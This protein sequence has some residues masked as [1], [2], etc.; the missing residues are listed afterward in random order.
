VNVTELICTIAKDT[1]KNMN[2]WKHKLE[3]LRLIS[4]RKITLQV[5]CIELENPSVVLV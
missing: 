4:D 2:T 3:H 1:I 5:W